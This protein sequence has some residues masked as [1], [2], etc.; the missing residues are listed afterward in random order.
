MVLLSPKRHFCIIKIWFNSCDFQDPN[1]LINI[2]GLQNM[3]VYL[4]A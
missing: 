2:E 3:V 4:K 1:I